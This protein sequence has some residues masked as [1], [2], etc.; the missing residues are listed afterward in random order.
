MKRIF[1][2]SS[3]PRGPQT[4]RAL[5]AAGELHVGDIVQCGD[6]LAAIL[7]NG[8]LRLVARVDEPFH[9]LSTA[10]RWVLRRPANGWAEWRCVRDGESL[11]QKRDR[12]IRG[13][14][15]A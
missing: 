11:K 6:H 9:F 14:T 12:W 15:A 2:R 13:A 10:A 1:R 8:W 5:I 7:P 3:L 4:V